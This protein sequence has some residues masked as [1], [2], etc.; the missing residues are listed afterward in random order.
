[1]Q[2]LIT[3]TVFDMVETDDELTESGTS[4]SDRS[5]PYRDDPCWTASCATACDIKGNSGKKMLGTV[6][7]LI[8]IHQMLELFFKLCCARSI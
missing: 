8:Q 7:L 6:L 3:E 5:D 1:V 4:E 2:D